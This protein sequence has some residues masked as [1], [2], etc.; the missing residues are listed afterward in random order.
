MSWRSC[1]TG[2][3]IE[4]R[5][6]LYVGSVSKIMM[7]CDLVKVLS[8]SQAL[9]W[10]PTRAVVHLLED[11]S[12]VHTLDI[13]R[14]DDTLSWVTLA[15]GSNTLLG[16]WLCPYQ[17]SCS[18]CSLRF[19]ACTNTRSALLRR[20]IFI[21][22][23]VYVFF[24]ALGGPWYSFPILCFGSRCWIH[25]GILFALMCLLTWRRRCQRI[26]IFPRDN[27]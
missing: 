10:I 7:M 15:L 27:V 18:L 3:V 6:I 19:I 26:V 17:I 1:W 20:S 13:Q 23:E 14:Y 22:H 25:S 8:W 11:Y 5:L 12:W 4:G 16:R 9:T 2:C 24:I 21:W